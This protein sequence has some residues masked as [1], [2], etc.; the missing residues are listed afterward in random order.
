[1][2]IIKLKEHVDLSDLGD[3]SKDKN[4][5]LD[6]VSMFEQAV[7]RV[8]MLVASTKT[9]DGKVQANEWINDQQTKRPAETNMMA[10][11]HGSK[12]K[13]A[14]TV[15][16]KPE[17]DLET[18]KVIGVE[19][20]D[21]FSW[22]FSIFAL[23]RPQQHG[24]TGWLLLHNHAK[25]KLDP[26]VI[27]NFVE[28][29]SMEYL[30]RN[31][32]HNWRH[33]V[34]V[35]HTVHR[36]CSIVGGSRFF[37]SVDMLALQVA[38]IGHDVGHPGLNNLFLEETSHE[39]A[40][41]YNDKSPLENMHSATL[42]SLMQAHKEAHIFDGLSVKQWKD[43]RRVCI[44]VILSTD[45]AKHFE[46]V[47]EIQMYYAANCD[48]LD[49]KSL[50]P[51]DE[52]LDMLQEEGTR[53]L[54][55][56]TLMHGADISNACKPWKISHQWADC[57]LA[58]FFL[59]GDEEKRLGIPVQMLNNRDTLNKPS[60]QVAF[61]EFF[62][63]PFNKC[64]VRM[65]P[66][67]WQLTE[68]LEA[69]LQTWNGKRLAE[70]EMEEEKKKATANQVAKLLGELK[71]HVEMARSRSNALASKKDQQL[72]ETTKRMLTQQEKAAGVAHKTADDSVQNFSGEDGS[73]QSPPS[74]K[75]DDRPQSRT[76]TQDRPASHTGKHPKIDQGGRRPTSSES[77][78]KT[79]SASD[80]RP[81]SQQ[82]VSAE[83]LEG[84]L[85][86]VP[87][88][89][90]QEGAVHRRAESLAEPL[91]AEALAEHEKAHTLHPSAVP[92]SNSSP[93]GIIVDL[94][95][96]VG[97]PNCESVPEHAGVE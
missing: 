19:I 86:P 13:G 87:P 91:S 39:L 45:N 7:Q 27:T 9:D 83:A 31:P 58:E 51:K 41:R 65:F 8:T 44:E 79:G 3:A 18:L 47:K 96:A 24:V 6:E 75:L 64:M 15:D 38:A 88:V 48:V 74:P 26:T 16:I 36:K 77:A 23:T 35:H 14:A 53:K 11:S 73:E 97:S 57:V 94:P 33:A 20:D 46:I 4:V 89:D 32:Y 30:E 37:S 69:N 90:K 25:I 54:A 72:A 67:L 50:F 22:S 55:L 29:I 17:D 10:R 80:E 1:M 95:F 43:A 12:E 62:V 92:S 71:E 5:Q 60:S 78:T 82:T 84:D 56:N 93:I 52:E 59:Q 85:F 68:C 63:A 76:K 2:I 61:I 42:F 21:V 34:D 49:S 70:V 40:L 28:I 66:P 81:L